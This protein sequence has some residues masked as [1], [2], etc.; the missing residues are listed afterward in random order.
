MPEGVCRLQA[1]RIRDPG[2]LAIGTLTLSAS[3][4]FMRKIPAALQ[5][6]D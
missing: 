5:K 6:K 1:R 4:C 2:D 3:T